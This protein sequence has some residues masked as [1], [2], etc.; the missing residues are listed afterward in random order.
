MLFHK[1]GY[2]GYRL[3][4]VERLITKH[5]LPAY[6][7]NNNYIAVPD[8]ER[9]LY[10]LH[11]NGLPTPDLMSRYDWPH[12]PSEKWKDSPEQRQVS[13]FLV[14]NRRSFLLSEPRTGKTIS[15]LW[16]LDWMQ[17]YALP[18]AKALILA[19]KTTLNDTWLKEINTHLGGRRSAVVIGGTRHQR[20]KALAQ[21]V[22]IYIAN[23]EAIKIG[24]HIERDK[25]HK[26][27][28]SFDP[29][30]FGEDLYNRSDIDII[31]IDEMTSF[32]A[33]KTVKGW[34]LKQ[35]IKN[36][37]VLWAITGTPTPDS[38]MDAY[39]MAKLVVPNFKLLK[40]EYQQNTMQQVSTHV[41]IPKPGAEVFAATVLYPNIRFAYGDV[42]DPDEQLHRGVRC[43]VSDKQ[44]ADIRELRRE[45]LIKLKDGNLTAANEGVARS[46]YLQI[47]NGGYYYTGMHTNGPGDGPNRLHT[48][49]MMSK[50]EAVHSILGA[51]GK[52]LIFIP[53]TFCAP[54]LIDGLRWLMKQGM[55]NY[56]HIISEMTPVRRAAAFDR[57]R[58][59][60][61]TKFILSDPR[62]MSHGLE[63]AAADTIIWYGAVQRSE[64]WQQANRRVVKPGGKSVVYSLYATDLE[65][66]C[67]QALRGKQR[68]QGLVLKELERMKD[69]VPSLH[70]TDVHAFEYTSEE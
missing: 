43:A 68:F 3:A 54:L 29:N 61:Y 65:R 63:L 66:D 67:F 21:D 49:N 28:L 47:A 46:K 41:W 39:N 4:E 1:S 56:E 15:T 17:T 9:T 8:D 37:T 40:S 24:V 26:L 70:N 5:N 62:I 22:D 57:F 51:R 60:P 14:K 55:Y 10:L 64:T 18:G 23:F 11:R 36:K 32:K 19:P 59:D 38:P 48:Y 20:R 45:H 33:T 12:A 6:P 69:E 35:F 42:F 44:L 31:V 27:V 2:V 50:V 34:M 25:N 7:I 16:A 58:H 30:S 13:N 53:F 52:A